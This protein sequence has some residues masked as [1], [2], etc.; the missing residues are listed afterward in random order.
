MTEAEI[1]ALAESVS[2]EF[3]TRERVAVEIATQL[4]LERSD[5]RIG[6]ELQSLVAEHYSEPEALEL[7]M[8]CAILT[9]MAKLLRATR[10][11]D[12]DQGL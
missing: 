6:P 11:G 1:A 5:G 8:V 9:G 10:W 12:S 3:T 2:G 4:S 7:F